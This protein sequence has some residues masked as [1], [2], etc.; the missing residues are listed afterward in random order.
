MS[1]NRRAASGQREGERVRVAAALIII[2]HF[3]S[4][5]FLRQSI[6]RRGP[7]AEIEF[8]R[9]R[10]AALSSLYEQIN[11]TKVQKMLEV[12]RLTEA[13][14]LHPFNQVSNPPYISSS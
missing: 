11:M 6:R 1:S 12:L 14:M 4:H 3:Y 7:L 13:P 8:W 9:Q 5:R 10:N 2:H